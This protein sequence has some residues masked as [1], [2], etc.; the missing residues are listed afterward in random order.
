MVLR[1]AIRKTGPLERPESNNI[2]DTEGASVFC[3]Q[4][5]AEVAAKNRFCVK[6]GAASSVSNDERPAA[7]PALAI[8]KYCQSCGNGVVATA[9]VCPKCGSA[10]SGQ[11]FGGKSKTTAVLLA[12]FL[13]GW[14]WLYTFKK[15]AWKF[16]VGLGL[17]VLAIIIFLD[18]L[19][20]L[21][22]YDANGNAILGWYLIV[23]LGT[24]VWAIIDVAV[25]NSQWYGNYPN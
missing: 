7:N 16:W 17:F 13:G 3:N 18:Y 14:T 15:D 1:W 8:A 6:C 10:V 2:N 5:G 11:G 25:K 23:S 21:N 24:R 22:N 20:G 9:V 12:V 4:C 19:D